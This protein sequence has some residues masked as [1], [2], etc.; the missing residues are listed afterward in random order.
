MEF[1]IEIPG[2]ETE[3]LMKKIALQKLANTLDKENLEFLAKITDK[4]GVNEKFKAKH[5]FVK[6]FL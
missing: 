1:K 3:A 6:T 4:P 5:G 2:S